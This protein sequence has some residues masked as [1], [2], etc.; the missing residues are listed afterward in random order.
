MSG[1]QPVPKA[2]HSHRLVTFTL[3]PTS[4]RKYFL[5]NHNCCV[6]EMVKEQRVRQKVVGLKDILREYF[7]TEW[8]LDPVPKEALGTG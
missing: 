8:N 3:V 2:L 6:G 4:K 5:L 7:G 1:Y